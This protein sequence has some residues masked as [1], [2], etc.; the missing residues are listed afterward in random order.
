[1]ISMKVR[2]SAMV[3][4]SKARSVLATLKCCIEPAAGIE[5]G[6]E[7]PEL[8]ELFLRWD[9]PGP[10]EPGPGEAAERPGW[11]VQVLGGVFGQDAYR[12][13]LSPGAAEGTEVVVDLFPRIGEQL[14][15]L[16]VG[17]A[18]EPR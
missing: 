14:Q 7:R 11:A 16:P 10:G 15:A 17:Q 13:S 3:T 6:A 18:G 1:M 12:W 5:A 2:Y 4:S 9:V 8:A